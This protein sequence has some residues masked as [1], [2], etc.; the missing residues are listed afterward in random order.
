MSPR[1][2]DLPFEPAVREWFFETFEAPTKAQRLGW[3]AIAK[4]ESALVFAPTG[5]GKTLAAFLAATSRIMFAPVPK[6]LERCRVVYVSPLKAL[7][8]DVERNLRTPI[9]GIARVAGRRGEAVLLPEVAVRTGDTPSEERA[10]MLRQPPDI[11]ITTPESLFLVLTSRARAFLE[12]VD[13]VIVDQIHALV[14]TKR[15]AHLALSLERLEEVARRPLQRIGLSATQ[16]PL[17]E[18]ARYLGGGEG[19]RAWR[20][21]PVTIVDAGA[22]KAFDL[23]VEVPVEDMARLGETIEPSSG[24]IPEG[25]ASDLP[26]R[27]IW[28]AIHPRL[29]ELV[30]AHR[31]TILFVNSRRLAERLAAALNDLAG[32]EI[33]RA[34]HG[35]IARDQRLLIEDALKA[36]RLPALVAT[37]SLELGIDMGAV[38]LVVQIETPTSVA[39]GMQRIGRASHQVE[40]VSRG[41]IFPKYRGDLL[42]SAAIT[43]AMKEG[44]VEETRVPRNPL[45]VLAQQLAA[46]VAVG[47]RKVD[48]LYALTRRAAPFSGLGRAQFEGVLDMLSGRYPSD[49]FAEL[50]PRLVWDRL[51]GV[52]RP[53]EGTQRLVVQNAGTIPDRGLY[54]VFLADGEG[55]GRRVG[56]LDEEMVFESRAGEVFVLGATSWRIAEITRDR[57]LVV[58]APGEPGKMPFWKA[59]RGG[60]PVEMG[61]AIGRLTREL[62]SL[63]QDEAK[64]RL[65]R[66]HDLD[67]LA[68]RNLVAYLEEQRE[69]TGVLPD[70][71]TIVLERTRDEMG[72]WRL[73]LLSP[74]GGRVHA[75]WATALEAR[76]RQ[77]GEAEVES[78]WSDDGIVVRLPERERPPEA[79]DLL[80]DPE[81]IEDLVARE[82]GGTSL[83]AARFREAA[84]RAL[85]LPRRRPG[86]RT[87]LWMQRKRAHDLLQVA[88]RYPSFPIVLEAYR[89][90]LRDVFDLPG[91]VEIASR[92]RRREIRLVTV[93]TQSPSPFSASLLFGYVANY[94]YEGDAPLAERRAQALAVDQ[95]QLRELLG[96]AELRELVDRRALADLE[97]SL[98]GLDAAHQA[99][100]AERLHDLLLRLGDLSTEEAAARVRPLPEGDAAGTARAWLEA[101]ERD[102]RAVRVHVGGEERWGAAEDAGR[103]RDA[104]GVAPPP[105]L[106]AAFLERQPHALRDVVSRY[107]R[108]HGPFTPADVARRFATGEAPILSA[109]GELA[110]DGRVLE[111]EFR[112]G[113]HG[114][115]WCGADV[116]ATLRRRSLA[117]LRK[118]VEPADPSALARLLADWQGIAPAASTR[119]GPDALLDVVEQL[120][121]TAFPASIL[122]RD[123]LPARIPGYEPGDL[124][125]LSAAGEVAWVGLGPLG[126]RDGRLAL[127]LA[128]DLPLLLPPRPEAPRGSVHD[129]IREHLARHGASFFGEILDAAG[130]GLARPVVDALWD[131]AWAGE[132]TNDTPEALRAFLAAHAV[133]AERRQRVSS[134]RSRRQV[135]P[136]AVGRWSLLASPRRAP[137]ATEKLKALAEQLLKRHGVLTRDTVAFEEVPGGFAAL[138][139]VLRALEEAGRIRRG[140]FVAGLGG[141]QFADP[142]A[143]DR[144][145]ALREPDPDEPRAFVL[146]AADPANPY[147]AALAWPKCE[148]ARLAR[149]AGLHVVLVDGAVSA[150]VSRGAR[151]VTPLLP[152]EEPS[153]SHAAAAAARALRRWCE[154]TSRPALGWAVGDEPALAEG[155]LAPWL[156][157]AGFVRSGP[158]FRLPGAPAVAPPEDEPSSIDDGP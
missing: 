144:L 71:R 60:R 76:L 94:L 83:F 136:S 125:T 120:Q 114:R 147:G 109:L 33:A 108:T 73:C 156:A 34:H 124:D 77:A 6:K 100:S 41:I 87:P 61:R 65:Q 75:P 151:Q 5:S 95:A 59:D 37:S 79:A 123:V 28:P 135:P 131:L 89:E 113:G 141:L 149:A 27:S 23:R 126:D 142:G 57:V 62:V 12:T 139:P 45:D 102:R 69:A 80:P 133:R 116:L 137:T 118:Q 55:G 143:L 15:G 96:E 42:A 46:M 31:S 64:E 82:L 130:G 132:V 35:S 38:D 39:S 111:G 91:L 36:G 63:G 152:G 48:D 72:D 11:L 29:L 86:Y 119:R 157:E 106:P 47:E 153:R 3:A 122:E 138:Y 104:L 101:L 107:A 103:L 150:V 21:R 43:K 155:P 90:C 148:D 127:F 51:R 67:P 4:G 20:P 85:L 92:V 16:R 121:G 24:E 1:P 97:L 53:R 26:R 10:R 74:W 88:A 110:K 128:D 66:D 22:K 117:A 52:V 99:T 84:A 40:A 158:G 49:E 105:G 115:E 18:V 98:Q 129:R 14:G 32:E 44:A 13:T 154:A 19:L 112:P 81:E 68:A 30:R 9:A 145:R 2:Q 50:R 25:P 8:V 78:I 146:A 7:A 58:P 17:E 70:D 93:D 134:F 56:E 140:Y 54:G